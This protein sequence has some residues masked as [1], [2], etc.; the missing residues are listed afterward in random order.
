L[1][2]LGLGVLFSFVGVAIPAPH[3]EAQNQ[4]L[5]RQER[6]AI[7]AALKQTNG[8]VS[9]PRGAAKSLGM[10]ATNPASRIAGLNRKN[11]ELINSLR[12]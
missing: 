2:L 8:K 6:D 12:I 3:P 1:D 10:K 11:A 4:E 7:A 5:K 9:A